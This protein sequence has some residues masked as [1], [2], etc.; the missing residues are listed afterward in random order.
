M[1]VREML[2][3]LESGKRST[4]PSGELVEG[5]RLS[6]YLKQLREAPYIKHTLSDDK[7][8]TVARHLNWKTRSG[9]KVGS[10]QTPGCIPL[11]PPMSRYSSERTRKW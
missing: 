10:G 8:A 5:M 9:L 3:L 1:T 7:Y 2:K 4:V 6:D 11:I